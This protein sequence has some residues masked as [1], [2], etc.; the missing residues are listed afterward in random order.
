MWGRCIPNKTNW[1]FFVCII[2]IHTLSSIVSKQL[3]ISLK[4]CAIYIVIYIYSHIFLS[5]KGYVCIFTDILWIWSLG[6]KWQLRYY[7]L[8]IEIVLFKLLICVHLLSIYG[9]KS[10]KFCRFKVEQS[11]I[12]ILYSTNL[13]HSI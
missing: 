1:C 9:W 4:L 6:V 12:N 7:P 3:F 13:I 2:W 11:F 8:E 10:I 5:V